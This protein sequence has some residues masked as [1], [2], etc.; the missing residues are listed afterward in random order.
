MIDKFFPFRVINVIDDELG[1]ISSIK[2]CYCETPKSSAQKWE[3][4]H[5]TMVYKVR[6][7]RY[8]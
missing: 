1:M 4:Y 7:T 6:V 2:V 3:E 5:I 8:S